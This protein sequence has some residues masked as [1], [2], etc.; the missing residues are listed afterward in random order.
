[1]NTVRVKDVMTNLA[2][3]VRPGD[4]ITTVARRFS[5]N[6]IG[7]APVVEG[8]RLVGIV[9]ETDL[10]KTPGS[11]RARPVPLNQPVRRTDT[12]LIRD[13]MTTKV[14]STTPDATIWEAAALIDRHAVRRLPVLDE[15]GFVV[16]VVARADLVRAMAQQEEASTRQVVVKEGR[17]SAKEVASRH[18]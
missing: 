15:D 2:L 9:S 4:G 8:G 6:R 14:V 12:A 17:P 11:R 1:M 10:V 13:V 3:T 7:G 16:G 18:A 5:A